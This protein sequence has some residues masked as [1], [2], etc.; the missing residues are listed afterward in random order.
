MHIN[1]L[2]SQQSDSIPVSPHW[3]PDPETHACRWTAGF[4]L[5]K[6]TLDKFCPACLAITWSSTK[7][8]TCCMATRGS[9]LVSLGQLHLSLSSVICIIN[10]TILQVLPAYNY[11]HIPVHVYLHSKY[12]YHNI[13]ETWFISLFWVFW[14]FLHTFGIRKSISSTLVSLE[15]WVDMNS[16]ILVPST[17][18]FTCIRV[19]TTLASRISKQAWGGNIFIQKLTYYSNKLSIFI[20][21]LSIYLYNLL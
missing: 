14:L 10:H 12:L 9:L 8:L 17:V 16:G 5:T 3:G 15:G 2:K 13:L 21:T 7:R 18:S 6:C 11:Q 20:L 19:Q 1:I 4:W